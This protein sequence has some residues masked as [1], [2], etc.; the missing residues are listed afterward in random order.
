MLETK[1]LFDVTERAAQRAKKLLAEK[2]QGAEALRVKVTAGGCSGFSY[3]L[4]PLVGPAPQTDHRVDA[5]GVTVYVDKKSLLYLAGTTLDY[6][7]KMFS[8]RFLFKNPN[9]TATCSC[10]ES[11]GV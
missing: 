5:H 6:E 1:A 9:A 4:E 11:F 10:G 2:G 7:D 8:R 3:S